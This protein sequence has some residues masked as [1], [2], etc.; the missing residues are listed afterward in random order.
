MNDWVA[1]EI[2]HERYTFNADVVYHVNKT[3]EEVCSYHCFNFSELKKEDD[4]RYIADRCE[5]DKYDIIDDNIVR[6]SI[7]ALLIIDAQYLWESALADEKEFEVPFIFGKKKK[8][9]GLI[10]FRR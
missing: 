8:K 1:V 5:H 7:H 3:L 9:F 4:N 6:Y 2:S 10:D